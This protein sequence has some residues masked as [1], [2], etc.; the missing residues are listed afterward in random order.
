MINN[1]SLN[2]FFK[3]MKILSYDSKKD[4]QSSH[5][6]FLGSLHLC[7]KFFHQLISLNYRKY[8][9][10]KKKIENYFM[11]RALLLLQ[12]IQILMKT[13]NFSI[14]YGNFCMCTKH[15]ASHCTCGLLG[16]EWNGGEKHVKE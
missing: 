4:F 13:I 6:F 12:H 7:K 15:F 8:K 10:F 16:R 1:S 11:H 3:F 2:K 14:S 5:E 9:F